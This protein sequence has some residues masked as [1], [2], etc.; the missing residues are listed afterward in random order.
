MT[1]ILHYTGKEEPT[2]ITNKT[3]SS[4][5]ITTKPFT[6]N[7]HET[8]IMA[9]LLSKTEK[10]HPS[11]TGLAT[12]LQKTTE[13]KLAETK[14]QNHQEQLPVGTHTP[15]TIA[16]A[17]TSGKEC[18][19]PTFLDRECTWQDYQIMGNY[20]HPTSAPTTHHRGCNPE[21]NFLTLQ[22]G[23]PVVLMATDM[24]DV[25]SGIKN[26]YYL[27]D[28]SPEKCP[29]WLS[30]KYDP[31]KQPGTCNNPVYSQEFTLP[32]GEHTLYYTSVDNI[33]NIDKTHWIQITMK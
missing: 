18:H 24:P 5:M 13:T 12:P 10:I 17:K 19:K 26:I 14:L 9:K 27:I 30:G 3:N 29:S 6:P 31:L 8:F 4:N 15:I 2:S 21:V 20:S 28:I 7:K 23:T 22:H 11:P 25:T 1:H 32:N 16:C 33:G